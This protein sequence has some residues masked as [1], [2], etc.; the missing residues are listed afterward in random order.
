MCFNDSKLNL[1]IVQWYFATLITLSNVIGNYHIKSPSYVTWRHNL[2]H[3]LKKQTNKIPEAQGQHHHKP[4]SFSSKIKHFLYVKAGASLTSASLCS[5]SWQRLLCPPS[6]MS[7]L[8]LV[9]GSPMPLAHVPVACPL[10]FLGK[11][12]K[13]RSFVREGRLSHI[14]PHP[15]GESIVW[16][17][18]YMCLVSFVWWW[19][20]KDEKRW[21]VEVMP[22]EEASRWWFFYQYLFQHLF[23]LHT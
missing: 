20:K 3:Y 15:L 16:L 6:V 5:G 12:K 23:L 14:T 13:Q 1:H 17:L 19:L 8:G 9:T 22:F 4:V 11:T 18:L 7:V 2:L 21:Q 10:S